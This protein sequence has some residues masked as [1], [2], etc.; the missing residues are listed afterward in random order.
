MYGK[1]EIV[2]KNFIDLKEINWIL[3]VHRVLKWS[4]LTPD[5]QILKLEA[6][7]RSL[8]TPNTGE[9]SESLLSEKAEEK[10]DHVQI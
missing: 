6:L 1:E 3:K 8:R 5:K 4:T 9:N 2:T 7:Q 10:A